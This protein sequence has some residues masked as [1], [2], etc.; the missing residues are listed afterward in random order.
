MDAIMMANEMISRWCY[1]PCFAHLK[2]CLETQI[3]TPR[4]EEFQIILWICRLNLVLKP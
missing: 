2:H 4:V 3:Q 1:F